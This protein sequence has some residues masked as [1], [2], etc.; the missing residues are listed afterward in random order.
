MKKIFAI[1]LLTLPAAFLMSSCHPDK[2]EAPAALLRKLLLLSVKFRRWFLLPS[3]R[4]VPQRK[5]P[6]RLEKTPPRK[7]S[8]SKAARLCLR[9]NKTFSSS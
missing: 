6:L 7:P 9:R 3:M 1:I 5:A 8:P 2:E 4:K